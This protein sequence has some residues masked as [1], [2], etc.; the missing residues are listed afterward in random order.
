MTTISLEELRK[1]INKEHNIDHIE[2]PL[3]IAK[4]YAIHTILYAIV[5]VWVQF[6]KNENI[7]DVF[8]SDQTDLNITFIKSLLN[9]DDSVTIEY[10][11]IDTEY[12]VSHTKYNAS[13]TLYD[14]A[15]HALE[16]V[17]SVSN[18]LKTVKTSTDF[19]EFVEIFAEEVVK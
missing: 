16:F 12:S 4:K 17:V 9:I 8:N 6:F 3:K 15:K 18:N 10:L 13:H 14:V 1:K 19:A 7:D 5:A 11:K 2:D